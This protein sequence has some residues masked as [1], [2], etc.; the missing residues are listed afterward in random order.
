MASLPIYLADFTCYNPPEEYLVDFYK[1]QE[2][3][4]RWKVRDAARQDLCA[5]LWAAGG[6]PRT[7]PPSRGRMAAKAAA[8]AQHSMNGAL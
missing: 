2:E 8:A 7:L 4:W 3:A 5:A 6:R 1:S